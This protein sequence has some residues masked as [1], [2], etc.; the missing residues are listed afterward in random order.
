MDNIKHL[1]LARICIIV[2]FGKASSVLALARQNG[3][4]G[5]TILLGKGTFSNVTLE[6]FGLN[7]TRKE[8]VWIICPNDKAEKFLPV[9]EKQF[10]L[11]KTNTGIAYIEPLVQ[12]C[13]IKNT[14]FEN[15][16][17]KEN[18]MLQAIYTIVD[19]GK[20]QR[21]VDAA[22]EAGANGGTIVEGRG[23]G[24]NEVTKV[25]NLEI[26]PEKEI[27][28]TIVKSEDVDKIVDSIRKNLEI[29]KA[30]NGIIFVHPISRS[31]GINIK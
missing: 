23:A 29:E 17:I 30:N 14:V 13:G 5:G 6:L 10:S 19:K 27:I 3:I 20:G 31:V 18:N 4:N 24:A 28:I 12:L 1:E 25:F 9:I 8:L 7:Q 11:K 16:N 22:S 2:N 26:E 15:E 21:V